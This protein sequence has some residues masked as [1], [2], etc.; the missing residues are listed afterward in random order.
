[1]DQNFSLSSDLIWT[2]TAIDDTV[3]LLNSSIIINTPNSFI[4]VAPSDQDKDVV[5]GVSFQS[6]IGGQ[7]IQNSNQSN[8][9]NSNISAAAII[10]LDSLIGVTYLSILVIDIPTYYNRLI[11]SMNKK[12]VSS[13]IVV[14]VQRNNSSFERMNISLFFTKQ[15]DCISND[16]L[17]GKYSC[18]Y[19]NTSTSS[20]DDSGC[21]SPIYNYL[22][23]RYECNCNHLTTFALLFTTDT[24]L[25][26]SDDTYQPTTLV[27]TTISTN[28]V[29]AFQNSISVTT[30]D[31]LSAT[32][33]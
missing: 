4:M 11:H 23:N 24:S 29:S 21:T 13:V 10:N 9:I 5:V 16:T 33:K 3:G 19:Y 2:P 22:F 1:M 26:T 31:V 17:I 14:K 32:G 12:L 25:S 8:I 20:W 27:T 6:N 15:S 18:S 30:A 7:L 28:T